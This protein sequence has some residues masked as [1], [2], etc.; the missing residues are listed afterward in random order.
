MQSFLDD[1][2]KAIQHTFQE[3]IADWPYDGP[4]VDTRHT[5]LVNATAFFDLCFHPTLHRLYN[6]F[7]NNCIKDARFRSEGSKASAKVLYNQ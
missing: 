2:K 5:A 3:V 4:E 1:Y 6:H 7:W